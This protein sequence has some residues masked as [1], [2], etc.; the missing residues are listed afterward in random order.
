MFQSSTPQNDPQSAPPAAERSMASKMLW[1][2]LSLV[3]VAAIAIGLAYWW[4]ARATDGA[5]VARDPK[6]A[7]V[8]GIE[9]LIA[10]KNGMFEFTAA[11]ATLD[12][13]DDKPVDVINDPFSLN[14]KGSL[15]SPMDSLYA[16]LKVRISSV[17]AITGP[18]S[19]EMGLD[20]N[21]KGDSLAF[22]MMTRTFG[23][24]IFLQLA[25]FEMKEKLPVNLSP[26]LG[27]WI[28]VNVRQMLNDFGAGLGAAA[29][30]N[31]Q[32]LSAIEDQPTR[33]IVTDSA[34]YA[35]AF[36]DVMRRHDLLTITSV[37]E[38]MY[39]LEKKS[40]VTEAQTEAFVRDLAQTIVQQYVRDVD[41]AIAATTKAGDMKG[42]EQLRKFRSDLVTEVGEDGSK[43]ADELIKSMESNSEEGE[44]EEDN[45]QAKAEFLV[46]VNPRTGVAE[47]F[48]LQP[49]TSYTGKD[50]RS[51]EPITLTFSKLNSG[52]RVER[53]AQFKSVYEMLPVF[54][55][56]L[57]GAGELEGA[58]E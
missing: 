13:L 54:T 5:R 27:T 19:T 53:P 38:G 40:G 7:V 4:N 9:R 33:F 51:V 47:S 23:E 25:A 50:L 30:A 6:E 1:P 8:Q 17:Y 49:V 36:A 56:M 14:A 34:V 16:G 32:L 39:Q 48:V 31:E 21:I 10:S 37:G 43:G 58:K 26:I 20:L 45:G 2:L 44:A 24:D 52:I 42:V 57:M 22:Q 28:N 41:A 55:G 11:R 18:T 15:N 29:G 35:K 12:A 46:Q 3:I